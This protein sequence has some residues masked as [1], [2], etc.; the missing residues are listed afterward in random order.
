[1]SEKGV[2]IYQVSVVHA[3][4]GDVRLYPEHVG[5]RVVGRCQCGKRLEGVGHTRTS[6]VAA[7]EEL[8]NAHSLVV[9]KDPIAFVYGGEVRA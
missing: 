9:C 4:L 7:L 2:A 3:L 6:A 1:M 8:F 5:W